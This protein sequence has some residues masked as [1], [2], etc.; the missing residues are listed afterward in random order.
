M[1]S[2]HGDHEIEE[3]RARFQF[4]RVHAWLRETYWAHDIEREKVERAFANSA[5][6]VGAY[7]AD[8]QV[9]CLRV[10][11]DKTTFA[12]IADVYVDEPHR[13]KGLALA[14]TRFALA[15]PELQGLRKWMLGT[16]DAHPVYA[17]AGFKVVDK[18]QNLMW[19]STS[20]WDR[21]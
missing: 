13:R 7:R 21:R 17:A 20:T 11:S 5:L 10:V 1:I 18:P 8:E 4:S 19:L 15:H 9:G 12:W 6:I 2:R 16:R 3:S 14:M